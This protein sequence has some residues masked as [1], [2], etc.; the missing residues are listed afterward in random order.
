[1]LASPAAAQGHAGGAFT[2]TVTLMS[3]AHFML[4]PKYSAP[5]RRREA[6]TFSA[7]SFILHATAHVHVCLGW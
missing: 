2:S 7:M 3:H 1:M 4:R 5:C 6:D